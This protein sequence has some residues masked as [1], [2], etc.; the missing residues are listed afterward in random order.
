[1]IRYQ[2]WC[3]SAECDWTFQSYLSYQ[4]WFEF[5]RCPKCG[6]YTDALESAV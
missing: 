2:F 4:L 6:G 5:A 3:Y 1:M